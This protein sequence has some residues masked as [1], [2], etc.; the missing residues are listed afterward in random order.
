MK[1]LTIILAVVSGL[2][3]ASTLICGLWMRSQPQV[4]PSSVT[5]HMGIALLTI[6]LSLAT[7]V[8]AISQ[9]PAQ[10]AA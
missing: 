2:L 8:M 4:D 9:I 10:T 6:V 7:I 5:F 3:M 1:T